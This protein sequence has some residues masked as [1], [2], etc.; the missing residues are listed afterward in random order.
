MASGCHKTETIY[1]GERVASPTPG[2]S[3]E[4]SGDI[5]CRYVGMSVCQSNVKLTAHAQSHF[6][7]AKIVTTAL[8]ISTTR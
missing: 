8:L 1:L 4:I 6:G 3:I 2:C 5:Y 7:A